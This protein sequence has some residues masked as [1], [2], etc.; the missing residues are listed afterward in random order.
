[1]GYK[2]LGYVV[3]FRV[4]KG[5]ASTEIDNSILAL[6]NLMHVALNLLKLMVLLNIV[7]KEP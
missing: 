1:M 5:E 6:R 2:I 4:K 3:S 7:L